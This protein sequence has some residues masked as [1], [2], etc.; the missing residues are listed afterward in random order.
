MQIGLVE[1][2]VLIYSVHKRTTASCV[3]LVAMQA[4]FSQRWMETHEVVQP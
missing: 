2:G 1:I 3:A 4:P